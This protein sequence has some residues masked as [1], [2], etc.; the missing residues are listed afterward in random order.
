M[1]TEQACACINLKP[2]EYFYRL[3]WRFTTRRHER[4][5]LFFST[6]REVEQTRMW[7]V[8]TFG[9]EPP[10]FE[11]TYWETMENPSLRLFTPLH[12]CGAAQEADSPARLLEFPRG[13][14]AGGASLPS[15]G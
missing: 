3:L 11:A 1:P 5:R 2:G 12:V 6:V 8:H 7:I 15:T 13:V 4:D 10:K 14:V 9:V